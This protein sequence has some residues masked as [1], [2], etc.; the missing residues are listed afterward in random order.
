MLNPFIKKID[1]LITT[2]KNANKN[3]CFTT[4][5]K[6]V[7]AAKKSKTSITLSLSTEYPG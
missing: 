6:P 5:R 3:I 4:V 7:E 2:D 1:D